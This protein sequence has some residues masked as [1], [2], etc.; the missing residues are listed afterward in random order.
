MKNSSYRHRIR[1][2]TIQDT[3]NGRQR[4]C[5]LPQTISTDA[6]LTLRLLVPRDIGAH[7]LRLRLHADNLPFADHPIPFDT[8][9]GEW[10]VFCLTTTASSLFSLCGLSCEQGGFLQYEVLCEAEGR[11][12]FARRNEDGSL[13]LQDS[14]CD[15]VRLLCYTDTYRTP[16]WLGQGLMYHIFVDRFA[17]GQGACAHRA[18]SIVMQDW[19]S[20]ELQYPAYA[21]AEVENNQF[22][23][24]NLWGIIEKLDYLQSLGVNILYL[25]PIFRAK[26]NHKYDTGDYLEIDE[27]FGGAQAFCALIDAL[28][29]RNMRLILDGVFNH[30]GNDSRYFNAFGTYDST[31]AAQSTDSVYADWYTFRSHPNDYVCWWNIPIL[32]RLRTDTPS[33][34]DY[35]LGENGVVAHYLRTGIDGWRLDVADELSDAFLYDLRTV[36]KST[37]PDC[38]IIG[39]VWENAADKI[40]YGQRR[41]YLQGGQLDS[42]MHYPFRSALLHYLRTQN[43]ARF[44]D[45]LLDVY[46]SYPRP[47]ADVLMNLVGT[48]DTERIATALGGEDIQGL[49]N[50]DLAHKKMSEQARTLSS[51]LQRIASVLQYTVYGFPCVYYGDEIAMEGYGDPFCRRPYPWGNENTEMLA[52][53]R[54]LGQLRHALP[55]LCAGDFTVLQAQDGLFLF[56][57]KKEKNTVYIGVN[58]AQRASLNL[59]H[60]Q[61]WECYTDTAWHN[62]PLERHSFVI[63]TPLS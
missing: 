46:R 22:F 11:T 57:R 6:Q 5:H 12:L 32:P 2:R 21:G 20:D 60:G 19:N 48:H 51:A 39:E 52:H 29:A 41:A 50:C 40:A 38:A 44:A 28:H 36:A 63:L 26:S 56:A 3:A 10:E 8:L 34:H 58:C 17:K 33:C 25:S 4:D 47:T 43:A 9:E 23:G 42:V 31:G 55:A 45:E 54:R 37:K 1:V 13:S 18:D 7:A 16:E 35:F 59:P 30:T 15:A 49:Q 61:Y 24:G 14:P 27:G 53:Y 62:T